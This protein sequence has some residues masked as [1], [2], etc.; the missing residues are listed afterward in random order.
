M[1]PAECRTREDVRGEIDRLDGE[2]VR[3]LAERFG[4]VRR[5]AEI[6]TDPAEARVES[7]ISDVIGKVRQSADAAGLDPDLAGSLWH[8]LIEWN[9]DWEARTI[10]AHNKGGK[11]S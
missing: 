7:R 1:T 8:R 3:L 11:P 4:Y 5:M 10:A 2:L 6:K 9:V